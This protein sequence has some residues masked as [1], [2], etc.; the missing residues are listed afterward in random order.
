MLKKLK[1]SFSTGHPRSIKAKKQIIFT[2]ILKGISI[3]INLAYVPL[4]LDYLG[5]EE[6]GIWLTI[7]SIVVWFGFFD[8]G[9]GNGLRNNFATAIANGDHKLARIYVS[10]TYALLTI[11]F[12]SALIIFYC[13]AGFINWTSVFNT[14]N[15]DATILLNLSMIVFTFFF[16]NF[17]F[18]LIGV[19]LLANQKPSVSSSFNVISNILCFG[20]IFIL[21][22]TTE[23]SL[24]LLGFILS[25][26]P[27]FVLICA[28]IYL[29]STKYKIYSP[30]LKFVDFRKSK[31]LLNLGIKFFILQISGIVMYSSTNLLITQFSSPI[32]VTVYNIAYKMF[33]IF[34]MVYGIILTPMWSAT[35]EAF[36]LND[37]SWIKNSVKKLQQLGFSLIFILLI[38]L[39]F[40]DKIYFLWVGNRVHIPFKVSLLV[41]IG[42][43]MYVLTGVY[44]AFQNGIGKIKLTLIFTIVSTLLFF[45]IAFLFGKFFN[46]GFIGILI[47]AIVCDLPMKYIQIVQYYKIIQNKA[48][49]IWNQ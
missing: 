18:Q 30:S 19:I 7:S 43:M 37:F 33:A 25:G 27:F 49:G 1:A 35:T 14:Q 38:V 2:F 23:S 9:L 28:N 22:E 45:P 34:T 10:T 44:V 46:M 29:F 42:A 32:D 6:Y 47:A 31:T 20:I 24:P 48:K 12:S 4:L 26:V 15:V 17:I 40:S 16:L 11:I 21:K 36:A 8:I 3:L 39:F 13:I 5:T 41:S